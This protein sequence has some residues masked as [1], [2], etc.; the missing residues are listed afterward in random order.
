ME[1]H[2]D[3]GGPFDIFKEPAQTLLKAVANKAAVVIE[4]VPPEGLLPKRLQ[5]LQK[6][7]Q[8]T[9]CSNEPLL[10]ISSDEVAQVSDVVSNDQTGEVGS[11]IPK[12]ILGSPSEWNFYSSIE[13]LGPFIFLEFCFFLIASLYIYKRYF[14]PFHSEWVKKEFSLAFATKFIKFLFITNVFSIFSIIF[15]INYSY[16]LFEL[17][18]LKEEL[19]MVI[20]DLIFK[21]MN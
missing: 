13:S 2:K 1:F 3:P 20:I 21:R 15:L 6:E 19:I 11:T 18:L 12:D 5:Q 7:A 9:K 17:I 16:G 8:E 10:R 14:L 4:S